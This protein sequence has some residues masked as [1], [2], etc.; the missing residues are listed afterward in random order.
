M[1]VGLFE[2]ATLSLYLFSDA[3]RVAIGC[4]LTWLVL[5][6]PLWWV[7]SV[8]IYPMAEVGFGLLTGVGLVLVLMLAWRV[9]KTWDAL[10]M[11][12]LGVCLTVLVLSLHDLGLHW[13]SQSVSSRYLLIWSIPGLLILMTGL[14]L[15]YMT[16]QHELER[17]LQ[18]ET[19][20]REGLLP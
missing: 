13:S 1:A 19:A 16:Q 12:L 2:I 4:V 11:T 14:I 20:Q 3:R 18:R 6:L 10:G 5:S 15:R 17:A 9:M 8:A 7:P